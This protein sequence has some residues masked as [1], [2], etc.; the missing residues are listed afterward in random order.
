MGHRK[1]SNKDENLHWYLTVKKVLFINR[2]EVT[3][4]ISY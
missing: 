4:P 3:F 1:D 2:F